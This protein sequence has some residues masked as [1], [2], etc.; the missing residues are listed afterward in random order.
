MSMKKVYRIDF[1]TN[2][3]QMVND[4]RN[5]HVEMAVEHELGNFRFVC[6]KEYLTEEQEK[7]NDEARKQGKDEPYKR[8][9]RPYNLVGLVDDVYKGEDITLMD[10]YARLYHFFDNLRKF[11]KMFPNETKPV[12]L[13]INVIGEKQED[14]DK[15]TEKTKIHYL[16]EP[17][18]I[19]PFLLDFSRYRDSKDKA[20][21]EATEIR[22]RAEDL[23][24]KP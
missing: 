23:F 4:Y 10:V 5:I 19:I 12:L 14:F 16:D 2:E 11:Y 6:V 18:L 22:D 7:G 13:S 8:G 20:D 24:K 15:Y 3:M 9:D 1:L 17:V 21:K